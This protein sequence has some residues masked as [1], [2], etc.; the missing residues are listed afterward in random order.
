M[1]QRGFTIMELSTTLVLGVIL[2]P[3]VWGFITQHEDQAALAAWELEAAGWVPLMADALRDDA[4]Q[5]SVVEGEALTFALPGCSVEYAVREG[6]LVRQ[7]DA[8]CG[9]TQG[10]GR[11]VA[12]LRR[13][14]GGVEVVLERPLRPGRSSQRTI[15]LPWGGR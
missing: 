10:L 7:A 1:N 4:A 5:G 14:A 15:F 9:G 13:V 3:L 11:H 8:A 12:E 6:A 2:T